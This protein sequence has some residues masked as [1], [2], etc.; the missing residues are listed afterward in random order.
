MRAYWAGGPGEHSRARAYLRMYFRFAGT[1]SIAQLRLGLT[2]HRPR[3]LAR[4]GKDTSRQLALG[5]SPG[6]E[7]ERAIPHSL[8]VLGPA[9]PACSDTSLV[10]QP[11]D[12]QPTDGKRVY[13]YI[14]V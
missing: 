12:A 3:K 5:V 13:W 2:P 1:L 6:G 11:I 7:R 4:P 14:R 8:C 10:P 9:C